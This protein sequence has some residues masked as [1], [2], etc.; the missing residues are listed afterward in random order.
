VASLTERTAVGA[1]TTHATIP[2]AR[3]DLM[4]SINILPQQP[5]TRSRCVPAA[6]SSERRRQTPMIMRRSP[7]VLDP[8]SAYPLTPSVGPD[9]QGC[10]HGNRRCHRYEPRVHDEPP[11]CST[12]GQ[13]PA[14]RRARLFLA[15]C[16]SVAW[17]YPDCRM[18]ITGR[19]GRV[20]AI[21]LRRLLG[22]SPV[23]HGTAR[24]YRNLASPF[25]GKIGHR[26]SGHGKMPDELGLHCNDY[27]RKPF[28]ETQLVHE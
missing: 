20:R 17:T 6:S 13:G 10:R 5:A 26:A 19:L 2:G 7:R 1:K 18:Q 24:K 3:S 9:E 27:F 23:P 14:I 4:D 25:R 15:E 21:T 11:T 16:T 12:N 28:P 22:A 8:S